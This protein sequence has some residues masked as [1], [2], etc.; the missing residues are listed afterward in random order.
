[1]GL[2]ID[3][4]PMRASC[5]GRG[6]HHTY[7]YGDEK[8]TEMEEDDRGGDSPSVPCQEE[9]AFVLLLSSQ[10]Q[11]PQPPAEGGCGIQR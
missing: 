3:V 8:I 9:R 1:M 2:H 7:F 5:W 10:I 11:L 4:Y 6:A